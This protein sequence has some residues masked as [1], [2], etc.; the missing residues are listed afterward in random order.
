[1]NTVLNPG[2][3]DRLVVRTELD[4][5][6]VIRKQYRDDSGQQ[7]H[8]AMCALWASPFGAARTTPG[9]PEPLGYDPATRTLDMSV[10]DGP[11][12]GTRGDVGSLPD[13][14]DEVAGLVAS[15]HTSGVAVDRRRT[16]AKLLRSLERKLPEDR[17]A[18]I[19]RIGVRAPDGERLV[20]NH[21]DF[22]PR[23]VLLTASGPALIDFDR[24]QMAGPGRDVQYMAAW[25]WVTSVVNGSRRS[26]QAWDLGDAFET[27]YLRERPGAAKD[28]HGGRTFHRACGLVRIATEWSSMKSDPAAAEMVLDEVAS[29]LR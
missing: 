5:R 15:L 11:A 2:H 14:L 25:C 1:M 6:P 24:I 16:P 23:N 28:I 20:P 26:D 12:L 29:L 8:A 27:A 21:G 4:G 10:V 3:L 18:L 9:L 22:S 19:T 13:H 7:I 17:H